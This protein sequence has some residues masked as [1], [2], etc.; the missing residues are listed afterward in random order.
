MFPYIQ[1]TRAN[2]FFQQSFS[3][4]PFHHP[5]ASVDK[6][7][8]TLACSFF[9]TRGRNNGKN[10][11]TTVHFSRPICFFPEQTRVRAR[12]TRVRNFTMKLRARIEKKKKIEEGRINKQ[13]RGRGRA[14]KKKERRTM[15]RETIRRI[16]VNSRPVPRCFKVAL[17]CTFRNDC[18]RSTV[19]IGQFT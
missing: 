6:Y 10:G 12:L 3:R 14:E 19:I 9:F 7:R 13:G 8:E 17:D 11:Q 1:F 2:R 16:V 18:Y 15:R 4:T 5:T